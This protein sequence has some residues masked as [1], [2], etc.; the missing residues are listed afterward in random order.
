MRWLV[1]VFR[2]GG[3]PFCKIECNS[4]TAQDAIAFAKKKVYKLGKLAH[5]YYYVP[6]DRKIQ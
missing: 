6:T 1:S 4:R 2:P 3:Q 5:F